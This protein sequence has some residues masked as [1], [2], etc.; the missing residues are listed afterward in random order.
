MTTNK[1]SAIEELHQARCIIE[2]AI[3]TVTMMTE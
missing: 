2:S 3:A 1:A